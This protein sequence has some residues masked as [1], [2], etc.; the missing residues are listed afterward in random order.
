MK[1]YFFLTGLCFSATHTMENLEKKIEKKE[2]QVKELPPFYEKYLKNHVAQC[3]YKELGI[4]K[5]D[6]LVPAREKY[7]KRLKKQVERGGYLYH[8]IMS[9]EP[10]KAMSFD[11]VTIYQ[12]SLCL[13][14]NFLYQ[15]AC[16]EDSKHSPNRVDFHIKDTYKNFYS[17]FFEN[18]RNKILEQKLEIDDFMIPCFPKN[19]ALAKKKLIYYQYKASQIEPLYLN[20][21]YLLIA[22]DQ[23]AVYIRP[24][25]NKRIFDSSYE[26]AVNFLEGGQAMVRN[27][28]V[29]PY[30]TKWNIMSKPDKPGWK[31]FHHNE[32]V[33]KILQKL[34]EDTSLYSLYYVHQLVTYLTKN[35][36]NNKYQQELE[37]IY[38]L[39][40]YAEDMLYNEIFIPENTD[41]VYAAAQYASLLYTKKYEE[42]DELITIMQ[43]FLD[44][45]EKIY[46][47]NLSKNTN[48]TNEQIRTAA[49]KVKNQAKAIKESALSE[50]LQQYLLAIIECITN[51]IQSYEKPGDILRTAR[52]FNSNTHAE[53]LKKEKK[54]VEEIEDTIEYTIIP[55]KPEFTPKQ[56]ITLHTTETEK[57]DD[58]QY[59]KLLEELK[60]EQETVNSTNELLNEKITEE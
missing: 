55:K 39:Y 58:T 15:F 25:S 60:Q 43:P 19:D 2:N 8:Q 17:T 3:T 53:I 35:N 18:F 33:V 11:D 52:L 7:Y 9:V 20:L 59:K 41:M 49:E 57:S 37:T 29:G 51:I 16:K 13:I 45:E 14:V 5:D 36:K 12:S 38:R 50:Q 28:W 42:A 40:P 31:K 21:P 24:E 23:G 56:T 32:E 4:S 30:L 48:L 44:L 6:N 1:N 34:Q 22:F 46:T 10:T 54:N 26:T 27:S 47:I